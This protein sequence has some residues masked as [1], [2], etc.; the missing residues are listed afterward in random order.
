[1]DELV[2]SIATDRLKVQRLGHFGR[3]VADI[4]LRP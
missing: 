1:L 2:Y 3:D 4:A